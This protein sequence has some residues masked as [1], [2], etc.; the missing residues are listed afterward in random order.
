MT[1][2]N[3]PK[4]SRFN[5]PQQAI[6][7]EELEDDEFNTGVDQFDCNYPQPVARACEEREEVDEA[8]EEEDEEER[9][10]GKTG[11][12]RSFN[13]ATTAAVASSATQDLDQLLDELRLTS[14]NISSGRSPSTTASSGGF[15][16]SGHRSYL[17]TASSRSPGR[18]Y[19]NPTSSRYPVGASTGSSGHRA[20]SVGLTVRDCGAQPTGGT[21]ALG[22]V[23][24]S[25][26]SGSSYQHHRH[27]STR[28][29]A[30][31]QPTGAGGANFMQSTSPT[32][33]DLNGTASGTGVSGLS[34]AG[35]VRAVKAANAAASASA[36][37]SYMNGGPHHLLYPSPGSGSVSPAPSMRQHHQTIYTTT[38]NHHHNQQQHRQSSQHTFS[39]RPPM[40]PPR[41]CNQIHLTIDPGSGTSTVKC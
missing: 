1:G 8:E 40:G 12:R 35:S 28:Y 21:G 20:A 5:Q 34:A 32:L 14:M 25:P 10:S 16:T 13:M 9:Y 37:A 4:K 6:P 23:W 19:T 24:N 18:Y 15:L 31:N 3:C 29:A 17:T 38:L 27:S 41:T 30:S 22:G 33:C 36:A 7:E 11:C 26:S 2:N 39:S